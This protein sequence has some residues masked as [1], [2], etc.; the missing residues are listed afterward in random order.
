MTR[1][2]NGQ[3]S[4]VSRVLGVAG[5]LWSH[6]RTVPELPPEIAQLDIY[7]FE[8]TVTS[9]A[10]TQPGA[11]KVPSGYHFELFGVAGDV[12]EPGLNVANFPLITWNVKEAGKRNVFGTDQSM[13][14]LMNILGPCP[15]IMFSRSLYL[16]NPGADVTLSFARASGW[17]GGSKTVG[18]SLIGGLVAPDHLKRR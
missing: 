1:G 4:V 9:S 10:I 13:A 18:V 17:N 8:A 16:F 15:P 14:M 6:I 11:V 7:R 2:Q 5:N 12:S 3:Q